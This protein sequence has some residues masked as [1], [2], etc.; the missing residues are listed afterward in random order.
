M[1]FKDEWKDLEN[2]IPGIPGSGSDVSVDAINTIAHQVMKNE[3]NN[4]LIKGMVE[5]ANTELESILAGGVD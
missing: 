1:S 3:E 4:M 5:G 2:A